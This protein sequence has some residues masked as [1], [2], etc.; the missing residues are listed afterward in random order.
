MISPAEQASRYS[1]SRGVGASILEFLNERQTAMCRWI[2]LLLMPAAIPVASL[3][4]STYGSILGTV[5]DA[6]GAGIARVAVTVTNQG[7]DISRT[8]AA[9]EVGNYEVL[10][11]K[12]G[13]Y[14]VKG[15]SAGFK[16]FQVR[17]LQLV[18]R[19]ALRVNITLEVGSVT[20]SVNVNASAPLVT[21]D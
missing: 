11:L 1:S 6:T 15:E 16:S 12:A 9:D 4:Q 5:T 14:S 8:V 21:T 13:V 20:E 7:E 19:Q 17:D 3:A 2:V 10:N 18:A